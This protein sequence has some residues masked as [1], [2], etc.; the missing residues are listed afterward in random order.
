MARRVG[1]EVSEP[2]VR[3]VW[4]GIWCSRCEFPILPGDP[5]EWEIDNTMTHRWCSPWRKHGRDYPEPR[6]ARGDQ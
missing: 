1:C 6:I 5:T 4:I 2:H 3:A